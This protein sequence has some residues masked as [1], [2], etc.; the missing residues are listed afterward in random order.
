MKR[1]IILAGVGGQGILTIATIIGYAAVDR[2]MNL[3]QAEVHGMSQRGGD[4][5]SH[6][7][8]SDDPV[9]SDLIPEGKADLIISVEPMEALR[10]TSFLAPDGWLIAN[11]KPYVNIPNYPAHEELWQTIEALPRSVLIDADSIAR[12]VATARAANIVI[13]GAASP[14]LALPEDDFLRAIRAI[15]GRKGDAV[16]ESNVR[17]FEAGRKFAMESELL[18]KA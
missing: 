15:F 2:G 3:K 13:L 4:V 9:Y 8:I 17:A 18:H 5:Q 10:Y 1:D 11:K 7:R 14:H 16:V 6:L 12:T